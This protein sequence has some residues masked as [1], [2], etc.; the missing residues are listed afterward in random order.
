MQNFEGVAVED[1]N[2]GAGEVGG[3]EN[4]WDEHGCQQRELCPVRDHGRHKVATDCH[5]VARR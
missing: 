5:R 1:G 3:L 2:D 4:S